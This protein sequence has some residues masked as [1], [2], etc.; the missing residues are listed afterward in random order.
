VPHTPFP[1]RISW[2]AGLPWKGPNR[3]SCLSDV[4]YVVEI[5]V[6]IVA[7]GE[8]EMGVARHGNLSSRT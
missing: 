7:P 2:Q 5:V 3:S 1:K 6:V 4:A 8:D